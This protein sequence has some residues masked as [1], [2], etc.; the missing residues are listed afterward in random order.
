MRLIV[1]PFPRSSKKAHLQ[2]GNYANNLMAG[3]TEEFDFPHFNT[4]YSTDDTTPAK[5]PAPIQTSKPPYPTS[6]STGSPSIATPTTGFQRTATSRAVPENYVES[7][8]L[9]AEEDKR[10]RRNTAASTRFR[11]K[12]KQRE[13]ALQRSGKE[14]SDNVAAL[15]GRISQLEMENKWLKNLITEKT[16]SKKAVA[17]V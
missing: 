5:V 14:I 9:A 16:Q 12:K 3:R 7:S 13:E 15:E 17:A 4:T 8:A 1:F 6:S 10:H 11:V 2:I